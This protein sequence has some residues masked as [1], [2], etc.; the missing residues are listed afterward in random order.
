MSIF[1][2]VFLCLHLCFLLLCLKLPLHCFP[3][4]RLRGAITLMMGCCWLRE[5]SVATVFN[6]D[7]WSSIGN[8]SGRKLHF[9]DFKRLRVWCCIR[10]DFKRQ[11]AKFGFQRHSLKNLKYF[12]YFY[13]VLCAPSCFVV[14][15]ICWWICQCILSDS[16]CKLWFLY[17]SYRRAI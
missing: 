7:L 6:C 12:Y 1:V 5:T 13:C 15:N 11:T 10:N 4:C 2:H 3:I 16:Q 8:L 9:G 17:I 14:F